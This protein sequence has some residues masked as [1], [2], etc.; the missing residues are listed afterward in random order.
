VKIQGLRAK[1]APKPCCFQLEVYFL[2][3]N[4]AK[5]FR[6]FCGLILG[7]FLG[8][9]VQA[10]QLLQVQSADQLPRS[11]SLASSFNDSISL[12][13]V[14]RNYVA[15]LLKLG[16]YEVSLDSL[17]RRDSTWTAYLH[18]GKPYVWQKIDLG[19]VSQDW[20]RSAGW[21][22]GWE[23]RKPWTLDEL[24]AFRKKL[25]QTAANRG[26]P[27]VQVK[28]DSLLI[29][30]GQMQGKLQVDKGPLI[31]FDTLLIGGE[32]SISTAYLGRYLGFR[33]GDLYDQSK[34]LRIR[35]RLRELPYLQLRGEP[36]LEFF[37]GKAKVLLDLEKQKA[38]RFDFIIG[39]LPN[40]RLVNRFLVTGSFEGEL[41]NS[42]GRGE[43]IY[44]RFEQLR[45]TTPRLDLQ[46]NYPYL[47]NLPL[48][49]DFRFNL[50]KRDTTFLDVEADL[51]VQ[52]LL[53]GGD[54]LKI[55]WNNRGSRLLGINTGALLNN[56]VLPASLDV[57]QQAF[58][59]EFRRQHLDYRFNPRRGWALRLRGDAGSKRTLVN[60]KI[61]DLGLEKLYDTL[62]LRVFQYR[63]HGETQAFIPLGQSATVKLALN[64]AFTLADQ[65]IN[66]NEQIRL[67][68][69]RLMRGFDEEFIF[70][71]HYGVA[72]IE[73]RLILGQ[74]SYAYTFVDLG[75]I[76]DR[77]RTRNEDYTTYGFGAGLTFETR[78]GLFGI[79]L[80]LGNR[81]GAAVNLGQPKV[82]FGYV[83]LF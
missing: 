7:L 72:S 30:P 82:H 40:S 35:E 71:T 81:T 9:Q 56:P 16:Y 75:R 41:L 21:Q 33:S 22:P 12:K 44:A 5:H 66:Q 38:S 74:N 77:T 47:A 60:S 70:A 34:L 73:G 10:Q 31:R 55:Y 52:Y 6:P 78:A 13:G 2:N 57:T 62:R 14:V 42:F 50:Y 29:S 64:A 61:R 28:L 36:G 76:A 79:S 19:E 59:L 11:P 20:L 80:A 15:D 51:G 69:A 39:L 67:G 63:L 23:G 43:R 46:G 54:Y 32:V 37:P 27:F 17:T 18:L 8:F 4:K 48:G 24:Q 49:L 26:Y 83:S 68:G 58:G 65:A 25:G 3:Q 45:P 53:E 1:N